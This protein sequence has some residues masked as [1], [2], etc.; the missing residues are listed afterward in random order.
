M[1]RPRL[2]ARKQR[3]ARPSPWDPSRYS[4]ILGAE[5]SIPGPRYL[6]L[7]VPVYN[8]VV[9]LASWDNGPISSRSER[10]RLLHESR[11]GFPA[12]DRAVVTGI[13][14]R[15][16]GEVEATDRRLIAGQARIDAGRLRKL[17]KRHAHRP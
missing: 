6:S 12:G 1:Q 15:L 16:A 13:D 14:R 17:R 4:W 9:Y 5:V 10:Y 7:I 11:G 3:G 8:P 2:V